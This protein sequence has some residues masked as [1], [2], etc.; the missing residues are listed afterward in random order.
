MASVKEIRSVRNACLVVEAVGAHQPIGVSELARRTGVDKSAVHRLAVTLHG[1]GWLERDDGGRWRLA[2]T[3]ASVVRGSAVESLVV[4][5]R[6]YLEQARER[7]GETAML[8][9]PERER[10]VIVEA[11]E[12]H[13][14]LRVTATVG[15]EMPARNS[16]ALRALAAHVPEHDLEAWRRVDPGLTGELLDAVRA[17]GWAANDAEVIAESRGVAAA[18]VTDGRPVASF[19]VCGP[20]TRF[21]RERIDEFGP[22]VAQLA[23]EWRDRAAAGGPP[24][25]AP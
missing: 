23:A 3:L 17:R 25:T 22:L 10:L 13:H 15:V 7:S 14:N 18:L 11:A 1:C 19:V 16:S 5:V 6:P 8:V 4:S 24:P 21:T 2:P 12:S 9:V 20:S